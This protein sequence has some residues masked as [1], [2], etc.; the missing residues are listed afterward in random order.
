M[1]KKKSSKVNATPV[2][3]PYKPTLE[4]DAKKLG[5]KTLK[6][7]GKANLNIRGRVVEE[8][9]DRYEGGKKFYR[10]EIGKVSSPTKRRK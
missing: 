9:I 7:G 3:V 5:G 6:V 8:R 10:V 1:A 2:E 4:V